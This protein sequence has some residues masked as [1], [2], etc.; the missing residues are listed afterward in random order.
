MTDDRFSVKT[1]TTI[2]Y[3]FLLETKD[4]WKSVGNRRTNCNIG[5][6]T[7]PRNEVKINTKY[8]TIRRSIELYYRSLWKK[9]VIMFTLVIIWR[10]SRFQIYWRFGEVLENSGVLT[11]IICNHYRSKT[12]R[13]QRLTV[14]IFNIY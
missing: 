3:R 8:Q 4:N 5:I 11:M 2:W 13:Y 10:L 9:F 12:S 7:N 14:I 6:I 1:T